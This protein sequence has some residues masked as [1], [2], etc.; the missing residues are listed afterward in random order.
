[1]PGVQT[2]VREQLAKYIKTLREDD[3]LQALEGYDRLMERLGEL[4]E[5]TDSFY[6]MDKTGKMTLLDQRSY[7][8]L[9]TAY[10]H[11]EAECRSLLG[12]G[13]DENMAAPLKAVDNI[14]KNDMADL[15]TVTFEENRPTYLPL[16]LDRSR[17]FL[18][19]L[20]SANPTAVGGAMSSRKK[21]AVTDAFGKTHDG[22]FTED[23]S[24]KPIKDI[25]AA[26]EGFNT[27][28]EARIQ[29]NLQRQAR[30]KGHDQME[31]ADLVDEEEF[32][33]KSMERIAHFTTPEGAAE[34]TNPPAGR[35]PWPGSEMNKWNRIPALVG[36]VNYM[37]QSESFWWFLGFNEADAKQM[38]DFIYQDRSHSLERANDAMKKKLGA[39]DMQLYFYGKTLQVADDSNISRRNCAFSTMA[40]L[41][42][43]PE[44][45]A[46]SAPL[47][48]IENTGTKKGIFMENARGISFGAMPYGH[49]SGTHGLEDYATPEAKKQL[50]AL[51]I[52]D[53]LGINADRH[54]GNISYVFDD[55]GRLTGVQGYDNDSSFGTAV[56]DPSKK[57]HVLAA[58]DDITVIPRSIAD[59][60]KGVTPEMLHTV[61]RGSLKEPEIDAVYSRMT[62]ILTRLKEGPDRGGLDLPAGS[63]RVV[64]DNEWEKLSMA[65]LAGMDDASRAQFDLPQDP[66]N[67]TNK[68]YINDKHNGVGCKNIFEVAMIVPCVQRLQDR[69]RQ[70]YYLVKNHGRRSLKNNMV[71]PAMRAEA[72]RNLRKEAARAQYRDVLTAD[73]EGFA[74]VGITK[75]LPGVTPL[76]N[77]NAIRDIS[78]AFRR[79]RVGGKTQYQNMKNAL[80]DFVQTK[81]KAVTKENAAE[82]S[83]RLKALRD[84]A[85]AYLDYKVKPSNAREH[86]RVEKARA[87]VELADRQMAAVTAAL[88]VQHEVGIYS[89]LD[90]ANGMAR[91]IDMYD[92]QIKRH[93][94]KPEEEYLHD[95]AKRGM[96]GLNSIIELS[97]KPTL[98]KKDCETASRALAAMLVAYHAERAFEQPNSSNEAL[99]LNSETPTDRERII[100]DVSQGIS[101]SVLV[102]DLTPKRLAEIA[103]DPRK[104][105]AISKNISKA[106]RLDNTFTA[107]RRHGPAVNQPASSGPELSGFYK[108]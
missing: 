61:L 9:M 56:P 12:L 99:K 26:L 6:Q 93:E 5:L 81:P 63:I 100:R 75:R 79:D 39:V 60:L 102:G 22:Y 18:V 20:R 73:H 98:E 87:I 44:V 29:A 50:A 67:P 16:A 38:R 72:D 57:T 59:A 37:R 47:E 103:S 90:T 1:M 91:S 41:L 105:E 51:Q 96:E 3:R 92:A 77:W 28:L 62:N 14:L 35:T 17:G 82:Y 43:M 107:H 76:E 64:E 74:E 32:L 49:P 46:A 80:A 27:A 40:N 108:G 101:F 36:A 58:L 95:Y 68:K 65:K 78:E 52:F 7:K 31:Y 89:T 25:T 83:E 45:V 2:K 106:N 71:D 66:A 10:N 19:D 84:T 69:A 54:A 4:N 15:A 33:K 86:S 8:D 21:L 48:V 11:A 94:G 24:Y 55:E 30:V 34:L 13:I 104:I 97:Q 85:Q 42:G 70:E 23:E 88:K 53:Y